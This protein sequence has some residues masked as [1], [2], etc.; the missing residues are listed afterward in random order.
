MVDDVR[1]GGSG[2]GAPDFG[3]L[4]MLAARAY[5]DD[6]HARLATVGF[7]EMRASFGFVFRVLRDVQPTPSELAGRLGVSKQAVGKVLNE[8][9][10]RGF[11]ARRSDPRD[12]RARRVILT[13]HGR[14]ASDAAIRFSDEIE[15]DLRGKVG[16]EQ[17]SALRAAL[18]AYV[19][20]HGDEDDTPARRVR[21]TW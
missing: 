20:A 19:E 5:A 17:V 16:V 1:R 18:L 9:E 13:A 11:V 15:A 12:R 6:L 4:L 3:I 14:A 8:M 2:S 21:P 10:A 7:P